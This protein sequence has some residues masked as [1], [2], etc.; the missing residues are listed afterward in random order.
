MGIFNTWLE[1]GLVRKYRSD[2]HDANY[3]TKSPNVGDIIIDNPVAFFATPKKNKNLQNIAGNLALIMSAKDERFNTKSISSSTLKP[4]TT[5]NK[6]DLVDLTFYIPEQSRKLGSKAANVW[7][8]L[9][10]DYKGN[11]KGKEY[12][13][14]FFKNKIEKLRA[15]KTLDAGEE[16][17]AIGQMQKALGMNTRTESMGNLT[18]F[19]DRL[20]NML[21]QGQYADVDA[22]LKRW[23]EDPSVRN[24]PFLPILRKHNLN[25][26]ADYIEGKDYKRSQDNFDKLA[27][28]KLSQIS[29]TPKDN[30]SEWQARFNKAQAVPEPVDHAAK[31]DALMRQTKQQPV[32]PDL[33]QQMRANAGF[34]EWFISSQN[35]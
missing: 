34:K 18:K 23:A 25:I 21:D 27:Q 20:K 5:Y 24:P 12:D 3:D 22:E 4:D 32:V 10:V 9:P 1:S 8:V 6:K 11:Y 35:H 26:L 19:Q 15:N 29:Q 31:L 13:Y 14:K 30:D 33:F 16:K 7:M 2:D 28:K 17:E